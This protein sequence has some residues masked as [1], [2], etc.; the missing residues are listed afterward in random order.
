M[1]EKKKNF[2]PLIYVLVRKTVCFITCATPKP[3]ALV[4]KHPFSHSTEMRE[5]K[6]VLFFLNKVFLFLFKLLQLVYNTNRTITHM[7]VS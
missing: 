4:I 7:L 2:F 3:P 6:F 1:F 5:K